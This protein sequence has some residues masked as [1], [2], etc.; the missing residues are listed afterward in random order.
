M[1]QPEQEAVGNRN[2]RHVISPKLKL[3][4]ATYPKSSV[5]GW[6]YVKTYCMEVYLSAWSQLNVSYGRPSRL[7][8]QSYRTGTPP[9]EREY[10][11]K[12]S[13]T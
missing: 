5:D 7:T 3:Y 12:K 10:Y 9:V 4:L 2:D 6:H 8:T 1:L 13:L 11:N